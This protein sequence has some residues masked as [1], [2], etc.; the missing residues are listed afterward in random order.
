M[1]AP[2]GI[3]GFSTLSSGSINQSLYNQRSKLPQRPL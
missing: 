2:S 1:T 3:I